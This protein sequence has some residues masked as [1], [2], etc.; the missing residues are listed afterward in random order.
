MANGKWPDTA[1]VTK[2]VLVKGKVARKYPYS[3]ETTGSRFF[4]GY[5]NEG[6]VLSGKKLKNGNFRFPLTQI[7][8]TMICDIDAEHV[9]Y[10]TDVQ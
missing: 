5:V 4:G 9:T 8:E 2:R 3:I 6:E 10:K 7:E 1:T